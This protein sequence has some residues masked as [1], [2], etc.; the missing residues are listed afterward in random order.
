MEINDVFWLFLVCTSM[1]LLGNLPNILKCCFG[2]ISWLLL[3]WCSSWTKNWMHVFDKDTKV[4]LF[5]VS[6]NFGFTEI[7]PG[8]HFSF[9]TDDGLRMFSTCPLNRRENIKDVFQLPWQSQMSEIPQC[10][11]I[12]TLIL[13]V[14]LGHEGFPPL[15]RWTESAKLKE[16]LLPLPEQCC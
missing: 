16:S 9:I 7:K 1:I 15:W 4:H 2:N 10:G 8:L 11:K 3:F 12:N 13:S 6:K 14:T 5:T